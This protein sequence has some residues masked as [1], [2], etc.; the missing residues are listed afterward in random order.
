MQFDILPDRFCFECSRECENVS[1]KLDKYNSVNG[2]IIAIIVVSC[3]RQRHLICSNGK[4]DSR[5]TF[6]QTSKQRARNYNTYVLRVF[7]FSGEFLNCCN[8][9]Y[10]L[11]SFHG[12]LR[13]NRK[14]E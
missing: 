6:M 3:S 13:D 10:P 5:N 8:Q 14:T 4:P 2:F 1:A 7:G 11:S 12:T 9:K